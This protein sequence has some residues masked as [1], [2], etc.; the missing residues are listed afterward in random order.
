MAHFRFGFNVFGIRSRH[1]FVERCRAAEAYGYDVVLAT[2]HLGAPAPFPTLVAAAEAT[3]R[4]R[5]GTLVLN[6]GFWNPHLLAREVATVDQLTDGRLELGLGSG[7]MRWEFD[8]AGIAWEPFAARCERLEQAIKEL[9]RLFGGPDYEQRTPA[10]ELFDLPELRPVQRRGFG[11]SGP[12]LLVGGTGDRVLRLAAEH[13]DIVG[14]AGARQL[15]GRP[16]GSF[17]LA[18]AEQA[19]ERVRFVRERAGGRAGGLESNVL[20]QAVVVTP[21]RRAAAERLVAERMPFF[22]VDEALETP[23]LLIGTEEQI[24]ERLRENRERF[25]F[26]YISVHE[27]Y[28]KE[29]GPVIGRLRTG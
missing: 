8:A 9:G 16:P 21:D 5:V 13:A 26:S 22:T 17:A 24:A 20:V 27:P 1:D 23:F 7:H 28:M 29:L 10:R 15:E 6:I 12:P 14:H 3:E 4:L 19:D 2:D 11:G 25:G 18:T